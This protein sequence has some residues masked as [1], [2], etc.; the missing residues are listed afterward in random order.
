MVIFFL[1]LLKSLEKF[2]CLN[3]SIK[4]YSES[5]AY[6]NLDDCLTMI[7]SMNFIVIGK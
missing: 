3:I 5:F 7:Y 2:I 6:V 4:V 1:K